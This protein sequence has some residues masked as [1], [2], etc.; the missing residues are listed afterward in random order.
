M[1]NFTNPINVIAGQ[2]IIDQSIVPFIRSNAIEFSAH[3][4]KPFA[5]CNFFFDDVGVNLFI[6]P[7]SVLATNVGYFSNVFVEGEGLYCNTTHAY[8]TVIDTSDAN[9]IYVN[10]NYI[11]INVT[12][13]GPNNSN[14]FLATDYKSGDIVY[15]ALNTPNS[16]ANTFMGTVAY[17]NFND[18]SLAIKPTNGYVTNTSNNVVLYTVGNNKLANVVNLVAGNKFP[19]TAQTVATDDISKKFLVGA[20]THNHGIVQQVSANAQQIILSANVSAAVVNSDIQIVTGAGI[21]QAAK[22]ISLAANN[23][24]S[25]NVALAFPLYKSNPTSTAA[26]YSIGRAVVDDIGRVAGVYNI[27]EDNNFKFQSGNRL[28]TINDALTATSPSASMRATAIF[29]ATG[30]IAS[31]S[32]T[33][34]TPIVNQTPVLV[35]AAN[36]TTVQQVV[37]SAGAAGDTTVGSNN[38]NASPDP[39]A[40]TFFVPVPNTLKQNHGMFASSVDLFFQNKP[41]GNSTYFP[42]TVKLVETD[43]GFPTTNIL[44]TATVEW[45]DIMV[46][47]G[48]DAESNTGIYPDSSNT[49]TVTKFTFRDPVYLN[50]GV[51]YAIIVYSESPDYDVWVSEIGIP[52]VNSQRLVSAVPNVG[53]LYKSQNASAWTPIKGQMLMFVLNKAQFS[54]VPSTIIFSVAAPVQNTFM[55]LTVLHS[56]DLTFPD[57]NIAYAIKTTIESTGD[58]DA[59]FFEIEANQLHNFG[60]DLQN[61][62]LASDRRRIVS[63]GN[64]NSTQVQATLSTLDPDISPMLNSERLSLITVTNLINNGSLANADISVTSPGNHINAANIVVTIS[65]PTGTDGIQATA[66]IL[67]SGLSGNSVIS[68]NVREVGAGYIV[69]PTI[70]ISEPGAPSNAT[71]VVY[72]EDQK[73]GGNGITK[74]VTRMITLADGFDAGDLHVFMSAVRP[75]GTDIEVYYKVMSA[76]DSDVLSNKHWTPMSK[77]ADLFSPDQNTGIELQYNTGTGGGLS[78]KFKYF[79]IKIVLFANDTTVP[80]LVQ[81]YRA[82]AVPAG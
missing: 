35:A 61:S 78:T 16:L 77:V 26:A 5:N 2:R 65:A 43:N 50:P 55:D 64:A 29:S 15:L 24:A 67:P 62:S 18:G 51:E 80:P 1:A 14:N 48:F 31:S 34:K 3:N 68:V 70:T 75:Q 47:P 37:T 39:L 8:C 22:I 74:Y 60:A 81:N 53:S 41:A 33:N 82:I 17:W 54:L 76:Q 12:P 6:Q 42:V 56:S 79:A 36:T 72:G 10:E 49:A 38:P 7:A 73:F 23:I 40:Q 66:N 44:G 21:G 20:Y 59:S 52:I 32:Q 57:A 69:S 11:S 45:A 25:L 30:S 63:A 58:P 4:L 46:T 13:Y 71:A 27:P 19:L 9:L 28:F